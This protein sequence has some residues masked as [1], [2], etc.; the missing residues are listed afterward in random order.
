VS[1][2]GRYEKARNAFEF[3]ESLEEL[4]DQVDLDSE[5]IFLM[6]E[7]TKAKAAL[8]YEA[9]IRLWF[10]EHDYRDWDSADVDEIHIRYAG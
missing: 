8:L 6:R 3:L 7:P 9:G 10:Q 4:K 1:A 5:R 2:I